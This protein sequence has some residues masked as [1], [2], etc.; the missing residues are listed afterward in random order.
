ML[1]LEVEDIVQYAFAVG[2]LANAVTQEVNCIVVGK[3]KLVLNQVSK[4][5]LATVDVTD[6]PTSSHECVLALIV[7]KFVLFLTIRNQSELYMH[8]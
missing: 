1:A 8:H 3:L 7:R 6:N 5:F 2:P 4:C